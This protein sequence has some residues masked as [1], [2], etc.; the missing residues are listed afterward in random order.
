MLA[1]PFGQGK[2]TDTKRSQPRLN[3]W[4]CLPACLPACLPVFHLPGCAWCYFSMDLKV[5]CRTINTTPSFPAFLRT[6][7]RK[8]R[9]GGPSP[10][11]WR[12]PNQK[13]VRCA[14]SQSHSPKTRKE[15]ESEGP[16]DSHQN[17]IGRVC[18]SGGYAMLRGLM[19][20]LCCME[21]AKALQ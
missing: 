18:Y 1:F 8:R 11:E 2:E 12:T 9:E 6:H 21:S 15:T 10:K 4:V 3:Q 14:I 13:V 17:D 16:F 20:C 7:K 19:A 5:G